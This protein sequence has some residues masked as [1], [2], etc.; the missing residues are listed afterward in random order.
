[1]GTLT[2]R[3]PEQLEARLS[4]FAKQQDSS[5]SELIRTALEQFLRDKEREKLLADMVEAARFLATNQQA[6]AE[7]ASICAEFSDA[8]SETMALVEKDE[9]RTEQWWK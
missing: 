2:L 1:M 5:R 3:L 8:D 9:A 7:S 6:R 4:L